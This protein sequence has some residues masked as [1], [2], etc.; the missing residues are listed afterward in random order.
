[1][2]GFVSCQKETKMEYANLNTPK[3]LNINPKNFFKTGPLPGVQDNHYAAAAN[4]ASRTVSDTLD[5]GD[6]PVLLGTHLN[7]PYTIS[8]MQAAFLQLYGTNITLTANA[9]Y[10]RF[11]PASTEQLATLTEDSTLELQDYPMD[12]QVIQDGDFYQDPTIGTEDI[13]W[14]YSV[15]SPAY[16]APAGIT[17]EVI[18]PL[19]V[20]ADDNLLWENMA[21]SM[22]NGAT[23]DDTV[24]VAYRYITR[25]D[26]RADTL[27][28]PNRYP[29]P[30]SVDPCNFGCPD[31]T[32]SGCGGGTGGG[33]GGTGGGGGPY[34]DPK[35][36]GGTITVDDQ[37]LC[38]F[39]S[40]QVAARRVRVVCKR[41]F[42][43]WRGYTNDQGKYLADRKF[44]NKVK[45]IVKT[46]NEFARV[47]KIRGIRLYQVLFP[48]KK[49]I[50]VYDEGAMATADYNFYKPQNANSTSKELPYW[51]AVT[52]HNS[53][54]EFREY[55]AEFNL[56]NPPTGLKLVITNWN[57][58]R[59]QASTP[60]FGKCHSSVAATAIIAFFIASGPA[61]ASISSLVILEEIV[62]NNVDIIIGYLPGNS[63]YNCNLTSTGLKSTVYHEL[64]HAQHYGQVGCN[65]W[66]EYRG[67]IIN[68]LT[69]LN[70]PEVH[71]Y[72]TDGDAANAPII[73][74]GEMWGNHCGYI[75]TDRRYG[76]GGVANMSF[77]AFMQTYP[78]GN[79]GNTNAYLNAIEHFDPDELTDV[80]RWIPQ[81]IL[82][83]LI[84]TRVE[85][86]PVNDNVSGFTSAQCFATLQS[87]VRSIPSFK[88]LF[89]LQN[90]NQQITQINDL[91]TSYHY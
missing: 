21:E 23:Y 70:Q 65:F 82:Y 58:A 38:Q 78:F 19:Y 16:T 43:I 33:G 76:N 89:L 37:I 7:N 30:C 1:M 60:M 57:N 39:A 50:G 68:E 66:Q 73:A 11:H 91:F 54:I 44:N 32:S 59:G 18:E 36:P 77:T 3:A 8:N 20:P 5:N 75:Y 74:T 13:P 35:L 48:V 84:D 85:F 6:D 31:Y 64:G 27:M 52:T 22:A 81:G 62:K 26:E 61:L 9:L 56:P 42:K 41:W 49:R 69:K 87:N 88:N 53:V 40:T 24:I 67:A 2:I 15:V 28:L 29:T 83:D 90:N 25:K 14:L 51:V 17:Y 45:I 86:N 63:D 34:I 55:S 10:V 71:P 4:F 72:G 79:E 46:R 47:S 12:Y 80:H